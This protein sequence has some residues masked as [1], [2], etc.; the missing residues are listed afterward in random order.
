MEKFNKDNIVFELTIPKV[1]NI[2]NLNINYLMFST[3]LELNCYSTLTILQPLLK[4]VN[5]IKIKNLYQII[6]S[7]ILDYPGNDTFI[8]KINKNY[9]Y[10]NFCPKE[11]DIKKTGGLIKSG[12]DIYNYSSIYMNYI[13]NEYLKILNIKN[14]SELQNVIIK[15]P[16][17]NSNASYHYLYLLSYL[18]NKITIFKINYDTPFRDT[19]HIMCEDLNI[20]RLKNLPKLKIDNDKIYNIFKND[21][22]NIENFKKIIN[23]FFEKLVLL[24][25]SY[26]FEIKEISEISY[27][28]KNNDRII[29]SIK[30]QYNYFDNISNGK[31]FINNETF[32]EKSLF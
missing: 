7:N 22:I 5:N 30:K 28:N 3:N 31:P 27:S 9:N 20:K 13:S 21:D 24:V 4:I 25:S 29:E 26:I 17:C 32:N 2:P 19:F 18:Y 11:F 15:F 10:I 14:K 23:I 12:S 6:Y 16:T 1:N 8:S